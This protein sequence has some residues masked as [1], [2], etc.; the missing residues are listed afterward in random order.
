[1]GTF[2]CLPGRMIFSINRNYKKPLEM[3]EFILSLKDYLKLKEIYPIYVEKY[4]SGNISLIFQL[5]FYRLKFPGIL[6]LYGSF[7][8]YT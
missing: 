3:D 6:Y 5:I 7:K 2:I 4:Q 1:M 8:V